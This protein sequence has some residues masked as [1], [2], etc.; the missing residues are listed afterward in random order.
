MSIREVEHYAETKAEIE[1]DRLDKRYL[2]G[3]ISE[4]E[5]EAAVHGIEL[6]VQRTMDRARSERRWTGH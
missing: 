5:Y 1:M 3:D 6:R 4:G 2:R